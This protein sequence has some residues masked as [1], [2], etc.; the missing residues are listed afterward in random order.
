MVPLG[1]TDGSQ[2]DQGT[3]QKGWQTGGLEGDQKWGGR[4]GRGGGQEEGWEAGR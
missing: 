2:R 4:E 3:W 1:L